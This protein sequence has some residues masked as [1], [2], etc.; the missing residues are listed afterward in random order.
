MR[1]SVE[2]YSL[3]DLEA[4]FG[5]G[6]SVELPLASAALRRVSCALELGAAP[7][8]A[9]AD[10]EAVEAYNRDDCLAAAALRAWLE[11]RRSELEAL[12][13]AVPRPEL[14]EGEASEAVGGRMV[15]PDA[16]HLV[17]ADGPARATT[18]LGAAKELRA[19]SRRRRPRSAKR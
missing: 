1:A 17:G 19:R 3:K 14:R 12:G 10:R 8:I 9:A 6:R 13:H 16:G 2:R 4:F 5:F 15:A 11:E 7:E 18:L